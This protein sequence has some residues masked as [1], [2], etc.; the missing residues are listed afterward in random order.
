[1]YGRLVCCRDVYGNWASQKENV[2]ISFDVPEVDQK[3][4]LNS[5][6]PTSAMAHFSGDEYW[7][8]D[9]AVEWE[10]EIAGPHY[11]SVRICNP[12]CLHIGGSPFRI[13]VEPSPTYA[14]NSTVTGNGIVDGI[15]GDARVIVI[16]DKDAGGNNRTLGGEEFTVTVSGMSL[17]HCPYVQQ[18]VLY[19]ITCRCPDIYRLDMRPCFN[20]PQQ[21]QPGA[22]IS[23]IMDPTLSCLY[24]RNSIPC[25][26]DC[27][28]AADMTAG[29]SD[30]TLPA[31]RGKAAL[32][33][34]CTDSACASPSSCRAKVRAEQNMP[35][36]GN[37]F[38]TF[39][40]TAKESCPQVER[41][42]LESGYV[43]PPD[44]Q[45]D[46]TYNVIPANLDP[47]R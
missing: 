42:G 43:M 4:S 40:N 11:M 39:L 13:L 24:L 15:A 44:P 8:G 38:S 30:Y 18:D 46:G 34:A 5:T 10:P 45:G 47:L 25:P 6:T 7:Q 32:V 17:A 20:R 21:M 36:H 1:M 26:V 23:R 22:E 2:T 29:C 14:P 31:T 9:Y 28:P 41:L 37:L 16:Q 27:C 12:G 19:D 33:T 35:H 3:V